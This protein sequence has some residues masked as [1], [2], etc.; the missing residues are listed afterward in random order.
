M[1]SSLLGFVVFSIIQWVWITHTPNH[2]SW[3]V[4]R[5]FIFINNTKA[6]ISDQNVADHNQVKE[7]GAGKEETQ[8]KIQD[9]K[10]EGPDNVNVE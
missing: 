3:T 10:Q 7:T 4:E 6:F 1:L 9:L 5:F 2:N 8:M